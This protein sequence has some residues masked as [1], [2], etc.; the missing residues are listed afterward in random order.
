MT[1]PSAARTGADEAL[2]HLAGEPAVW[3]RV[4]AV[5]DETG[6]LLARLVELTSGEAPPGW[7]R[8]SW[9]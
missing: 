6:V 3:V 2:T 9:E 1:P 4:A 5:V 8:R 7:E